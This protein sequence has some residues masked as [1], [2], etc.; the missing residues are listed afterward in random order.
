M[1]YKLLNTTKSKKA[2]MLVQLL[3]SGMLGED[4]RHGLYQDRIQSAFL[5]LA[6][7]LV[8]NKFNLD[9]DK[10]RVELEPMMTVPFSNQTQLKAL[11][12]DIRCEDGS[13]VI[14]KDSLPY[15]PKN[16]MFTQQESL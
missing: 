9:K 15:I 12:L 8:A 7:S 6:A 4:I 3:N 13:P 11:L 2:M 16:P 5:H 1:K 10:V 14:M